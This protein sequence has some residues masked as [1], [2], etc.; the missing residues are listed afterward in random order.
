MFIPIEFQKVFQKTQQTAIAMQATYCD[1]VDSL[2]SRLGGLPY[3]QADVSFPV[4]RA[5]EPL[6]LL[7]QIN[8]AEV[9]AH[10]DLPKAG[11]LQYFLP[12]R[13]DYYGA[14]LDEVGGASQ[15]VCHF[16]P[17]PDAQANIADES[18]CP[19]VTDSDL[20]PIFGAHALTFEE[21]PDYAGIDTIECAQAL[22]ANPFEV[23]EDISLNE[24]EESLFFDAISDYVAG[25]GHK[26]LGYPSFM[27]G[28]PRENSD[29]RLLLQIDTD[30]DGDNDIL[31]GDDGIA[32]LFI[33]DED[34]RA[35]RFSR[36][37]LFWDY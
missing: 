27:R 4:D 22:D 34:L 28:D 37:W 13:D 31:W 1:E 8:F 14:N 21:K 6:A 19:A 16:W 36:A 17:Q 15:L 20:F 5:G 33:R 24:K 9:P 26:L 2:A 25:Q 29:Y 12:R 10:P 23:L 35:Q 11:L 7:V 32:Q 30:R 18:L 3:W